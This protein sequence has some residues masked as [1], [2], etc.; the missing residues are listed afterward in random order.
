MSTAAE[1]PPSTATTTTTTTSAAPGNNVSPITYV[2]I[3]LV[4]LASVFLVG[5]FA[6]IRRRHSRRHALDSNG[7]GGE[8]QMQE[9]RRGADTGSAADRWPPASLSFNWWF[10]R[11]N[12]G[13]NELGE[14]P[15]P[16]IVERRN[17]V[18]SE[19]SEHEDVIEEEEEEDEE[20]GG[21]RYS[22]EPLRQLARIGGE[23]VTSQQSGNGRRSSEEPTQASTQEEQAQ[24]LTHHAVVEPQGN[25]EQ[26]LHTET[27]ASLPFTMP[28]APSDPS[29]SSSASS[30]SPPG[31]DRRQP[32]SEMT[33]ILESRRLRSQHRRSP[34]ATTTTSAS[35]STSPTNDICRSEFFRS[36]SLSPE[37]SSDRRHHIGRLNRRLRRLGYLTSETT[38]YRG[39][40]LRDMEDGAAPPSY[41]R[42]PDVAVRLRRIRP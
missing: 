22:G 37:R 8:A 41:E 13:L 6:Y 39:L 5:L 9:H 18:S 4:T 28:A 17:K 26:V 33:S 3:P 34:R 15:P 32:P 20:N 19:G 38:E 24:Q 35:P 40:Q 36:R 27:S 14:A 23:N 11:S 42:V 21:L 10:L 7:D 16:Y 2:I 30:S 12:E 1:P 25:I 31:H 29:S